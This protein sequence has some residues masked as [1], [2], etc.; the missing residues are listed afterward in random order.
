MVLFNAAKSCFL[1]SCANKKEH[2]AKRINIKDRL[3]FIL[4]QAVAGSKGNIPKFS[5]TGVTWGFD[6]SLLCTWAAEVIKW[7]RNKKGENQLCSLRPPLAKPSAAVV[8]LSR[9]KS[10]LL[11]NDLE[12]IAHFSLLN[13]NL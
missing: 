8:E 11:I 4:N 7:R 13:G 10:N 1:P 9:L 3:R 5:S 6:W 12:Q 2:P